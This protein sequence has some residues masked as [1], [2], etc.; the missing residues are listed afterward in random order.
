MDLLAL[1]LQLSRGDP[2]YCLSAPALRTRRHRGT[3]HLPP[4]RLPPALILPPALRLPPA[5][6]LLLNLI[7][8]KL[9]LFPP[10][11]EVGKLRWFLVEVGSYIFL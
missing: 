8:A 2:L 6:I 10:G 9:I 7:G 11:P 4:L 5:L 3:H 1:L